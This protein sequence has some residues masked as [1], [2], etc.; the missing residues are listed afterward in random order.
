MHQK[1]KI[2]KLALYKKNTQKPKTK[3]NQQVLVNP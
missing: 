3:L 1:H 2:I